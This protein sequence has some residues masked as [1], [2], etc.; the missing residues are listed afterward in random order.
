MATRGRGSRM[1]SLAGTEIF[2]FADKVAGIAELAVD[3]GKADIG[4]I[5]HFLE[6]LHDLFANGGGG[7]FATILLLELLHYLIDGFLDEF[8]ADGSFLTCFLEAENEFTTIEGFV[9]SIAFDGSKV[10]TLNL[11]VGGESVVA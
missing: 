6:A 4:D 10:F 3:G 2:Y 11:F 9:A 8:G 5:V 7:D 1:G